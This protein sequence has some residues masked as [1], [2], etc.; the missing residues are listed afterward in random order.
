MHISRAGLH[1]ARVTLMTH[2]V[3][4]SRNVRSRSRRV[5]SPPA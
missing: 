3:P 4:H 2:S 1:A 5:L